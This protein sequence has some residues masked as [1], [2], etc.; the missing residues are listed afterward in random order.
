MMHH[1]LF[2]VERDCRDGSRWLVLALV[3]LALGLSVGRA[4]SVIPPSFPELVNE[5]EFIA[6]AKV[7]SVRCAWVDSPQGRIIKTYVTLEVQKR[8]KGEPPSEIT[9]QLLGGELDGQSMR[10]AG[11]PQFTVGEIE[12]VFV[13][14]NGVRFCPLIGMMHG[15]YHV[16]SDATRGEYV[17]RSDGVP[18]ENESDVQLPQ[19][20]SAVVDRLKS[21]ANALSAQSFE[22][23]I[24]HE[25]TRRASVP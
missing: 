7:K 6:R 23:K 9:L 16:Q 14:G 1:R 11:M 18:L 25:V 10:V 4:T 13:K 12:I 15:R 8:L 20:Q 5:A 3:F 19:G 17:A 21:V 2:L 22:Q 24:A